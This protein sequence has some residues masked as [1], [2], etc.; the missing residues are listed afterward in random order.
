M[1]CLID[2]LLLILVFYCLSAVSGAPKTTDED[3]L[4]LVHILFRHGN[5]TPDSIPY[6]NDPISNESYYMPYGM[7]QITNK[8]KRT[9]YRMGTSLRK[10]YDNFLGDTYNIDLLDARTTNFNR[11]KMSL[12]SML[13][14]L[15]PP[16]GDQ[17]WK[18]W[19]NWQ[20]IPYNHL[21]NDKE[22]GSTGI[23][24]NYI[25]LVNELENSDEI[26][27]LLSKY[28]DVYEYVSEHA[29]TNVSTPNSVF[30][31]Y[32][33]GDAQRDFGYALESWLESVWSDLEKI[34]KDTYYIATNT[35]TLKKIAGGFLLRKIINDSKAKIEQT[36]IP[37][38]RK[39]FI[40]SGH[41]VN[42]AYLLITLGVYDDSIPT[43]GSYVSIEL[44]RIDGIVGFKVFYQNWTTK[45]PILL[46]I[47][48][49]DAFCPFDDFVDLL[50]EVIPTDDDCTIS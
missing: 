32:F 47:P 29:G 8:G 25:E 10:R 23:C 34:T 4:V 26:Q 42:I 6:K 36:L 14:G 50:S 31:L 16:K 13:A 46:T 12:Q 38:H 39:M 40:Y 5:R 44:H 2:T 27:K 21:L 19:L 20:P 30:G 3:T 41:E 45:E 11:T 18:P 24:E 7:G 17:I 28:K 33:F 35:T 1:N 43:Y 15:W 22:L 48:G 9:A 49:C 37:Q